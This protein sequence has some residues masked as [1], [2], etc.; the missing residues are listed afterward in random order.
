MKCSIAIKHVFI[1][2]IL[3]SITKCTTSLRKSQIY[4]EVGLSTHFPSVRDV[5]EFVTLS[6]LVYDLRKHKYCR[7]KNI[8]CHWY[9][10]LND[11]A[12]VMVVSS[13]AK[14]YIAVVFAGNF[15]LIQQM[16][17]CPRLTFLFNHQP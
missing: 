5:N 12:Q 4:N 13:K 7:F 10:N 15:E 2:L 1:F 11:G 3:I 6:K 14:N 8:I 17:K 16:K 9:K